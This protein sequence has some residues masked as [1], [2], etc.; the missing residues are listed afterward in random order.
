MKVLRA[1]ALT[2]CLAQGSL[3]RAPTLGLTRWRGGSTDVQPPSK[4][5]RGPA[6]GSSGAV[7][8]SPLPASI[9]AADDEPPAPM[10]LQLAPQSATLAHNAIE[11]PQA[12][13]AALGIADGSLVRLRGKRRNTVAVVTAIKRCAVSPA[14]PVPP[15]FHSSL[16]PHP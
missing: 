11:V 2:L 13:L 6:K 7:G 12:T 3:A 5:R 1:V 15:R 16:R 8:T 10:L 14:P 4:H 9:T